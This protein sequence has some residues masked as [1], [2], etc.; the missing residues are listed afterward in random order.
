M[1]IFKTSETIGLQNTVVTLGKFDG[2]H[3]GHQSLL[4]QMVMEKENHHL[5]SVVFSF[6][7][8]ST[9][10][11]GSLT[12]QQ[13][14]AYL[15][16]KFGADYLVLF[17]ANK[18]TMQMQPEEFIKTVLIESLGAKIIITGADFR[19]G[20]NRTGSV[21][22][23]QQYA[24]QYGYSVVVKEDCVYENERISSSRIKQ[25]L[26][27]GD[28]KKAEAMLGYP[29]FMIGKI[30][31]GKQLG[32]TMGIRTLNMEVDA[33]KIMLKKGVYATATE[34]DGL[35]YQSITNIGTCPTVC[36]KDC[37]SVETHVF[38]FNDEIYGEEVL[39]NFFGFVREEKKF[40]SI[41]EL[42]KQIEAD[43]Q[44]VK[45]YDGV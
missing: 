41:D 45:N 2:M 12:T 24:A 8:I 27:T 11:G 36:T 16:E 4:R 43:I 31:K 37:I 23:L 42:Q 15:A 34:I 19:F 10:G 25:E 30:I 40:K 6:D 32:R 21:E 3:L 17:P 38:D 5:S 1:K 13:E 29:Y 39:V 44:F 14:R 28:L 7:I 26:Q 22:T 35:T 33:K 18:E 9:M 20:K